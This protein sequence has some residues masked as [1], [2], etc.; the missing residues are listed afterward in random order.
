MA[1]SSTAVAW[2]IPGHMLSGTIAYQ[3]LQQEN[4]Q[5]IDKV[6][7]V[8]EKHPWY[9]NQWQARLQDVP[10]ADHD[11]VLFM[12]AARWADDIR[13]KDKQHHRAPWH[14]IN[15]PFKPEGQ[16]ASVQIREPEP[17]NILTAMAENES[18]VKNEND[19]ER[20][21][22]AL[23]W[24]FHLVGDIHQPLHTAQLFTVDYPKGD[25][26][27]NEICVRVTQA[28]QPMDLHRFWD[29]V[30]T[31]SSNLTR[32]RNEATALRN[33]QEFQRSQ[34]T[35][36]ASTDFES[37][38]KESFE[39]AT[40]IAYRNGGRIGIPKGGNMDCAMVAAAPVLPA[41]YV[42]SASRIADR[43]MIL[44]G[45]RLAD[46]LTRAYSKLIEGEISSILA[47]RLGF[48]PS[49]D[50][51]IRSRQHIRWNRQ[52][53]LLRGFEIN[54]ELK[55][56]WLLYGQISRLCSLQN[57]VDHRRAA[58]VGFGPVR[59]VGHQATAGD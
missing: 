10:V 28:G 54:H 22:I 40:K 14:Y 53:D 3:V 12:Q 16:P 56:R 39:I 26:G 25:R 1:L 55:L 38:A 23:A 5:T 17:V 6:K 13:R 41:G 18:V 20:K 8:L 34:L 57:L 49:L 51:F 30:I 36:L 33:R 35:E 52:A 24:L 2:N 11:L 59:P 19:P 15:W 29:G 37:W 4:P 45:Y 21:A 48:L 44:A 7:A 58:P 32:L 42:V 47:S 43:R 31:S 27:G 9:A 50:H 46:L